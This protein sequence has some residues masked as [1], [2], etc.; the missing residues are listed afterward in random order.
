MSQVR[1]ILAWLILIA[2]PAAWSQAANDSLQALQNSFD[3]II[4]AGRFAKAQWGVKVVSLD[5]AETLYDHDSER[6]LMPASNNKLLTGAIALVRLG[7]DFRYQT[8]IMAEGSITDGILRG[9]LMIVGSGDPSMAP[10]FYS[11]DPFGTFREWAAILKDKGIRGIEGDIAGNGSAFDYPGLGEGWQWDDLPYGYATP[12]SALQF[13]ENQITLE[14]TPGANAG[15]PVSI[16]TQ[17]LE[18]YMT[19]ECRV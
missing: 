16:R 13:N 19:V 17:P 10:R 15:D 11:G 4:A 5:R 3:K 9:N 7:P 12:V 1:L 2:P 14:I 6:L 18:D 8:R